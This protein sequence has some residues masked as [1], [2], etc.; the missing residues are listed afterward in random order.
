MTARSRAL[1][2]VVLALLAACGPS[3]VPLFSNQTERDANEMLATLRARDI[4]ARKEILKGG[5]VTVMVADADFVKAMTAL[6]AE[7]LPRQPKPTVPDLFP[8]DKMFTSP[9]E[10]NVRIKF[11]LEQEIA[12][13]LT[14]IQGVR[15]ARVVLVMPDPDPHRDKRPTSASVLLI[16]D[17]LLDD[18]GLVTRIKRFVL[19]SVPGLT[20]DHISIS[21]FPFN[22]APPQRTADDD[23]K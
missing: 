5:T 4:K 21:L 22:Q 23:T 9:A 1:A 19:D 11:A 2:I 3:E 6:H 18:L 10:E 13:S 8:S 17:E 20:E 7:G 14:M 15:D 16:H 12:Q